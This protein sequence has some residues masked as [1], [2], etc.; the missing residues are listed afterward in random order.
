MNG[1][2]SLLF[3]IMGG[4]A[5]FMKGK[6]EQKGGDFSVIKNNSENAP[7]ESVQE[8]VDMTVTPGESST[9]VPSD[10]TISD[11]IND[12]SLLNKLKLT[13]PEKYDQLTTHIWRSLDYLKQYVR[14]TKA[15]TGE[16]VAPFAS[17]EEEVLRLLQE[18]F[19]TEYV[20]RSLTGQYWV[21]IF[22][23]KD[24]NIGWRGD[25]KVGIIIYEVLMN[26][27]EQGMVRVRDYMLADEEFPD[28]D[29]YIS[30]LNNK[31]ITL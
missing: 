30:Q 9:S 20:G 26:F 14:D 3:T 5:L 7:S 6:T 4:V 8:D 24:D 18:G 27:P 19:S 11:V 16:Y 1:W 28:Y 10:V 17:K 29:R 2:V 23:K 22:T 21:E 12:P 31:Y 13:D 25:E 15:T